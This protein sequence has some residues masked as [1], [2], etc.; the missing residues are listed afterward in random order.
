L[1]ETLHLL[2]DVDIPF[3]VD[4]YGKDIFT[5]KK[6]EDYYK[7]GVGLIK[8]YHLEN[9]VTLH[10][11]VENVYELIPKFDVLCLPSFHEGFSNSLSEYICCG[12]PVLCSDVS[13]NCIMV[14]NGVNGFLFDPDCIESMASA[15]RKYFALTKEQRS[16]MGI[17]S[18]EIAESLFDENKF[19]MDY[20]NLIE[21]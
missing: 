18:R 11:N 13:D 4:W 10:S 9:I 3:H 20:V 17:K 14:K 21:D 1:I 8:K 16:I 7:E 5:N 2:S 6:L 15:F 19:I 12:R